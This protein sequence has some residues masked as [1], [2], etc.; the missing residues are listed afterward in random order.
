MLEIVDELY[1]Q[2]AADLHEHF[3]G[4]M[5]RGFNCFV[6]R[7]DLFYEMCE[8]EFGVLAEME[9]RLDIANYSQMLT[10][11]YG[12]MAELLYSAFIRTL[13]KRG[14]LRIYEPQMLFFQDTEPYVPLDPPENE[15]DAVALAFVLEAD[16][17]PSV[18]AVTL[19]SLLQ[20]VDTNRHYDI[21]LFSFD[22]KKWWQEYLSSLCGKH[23]NVTIRFANTRKIADSIWEYKE[24]YVGIRALLPYVLPAYNKIVSF[25][26]NMLFRCDPAQLFD[27]DVSGFPMLVTYDLNV[28][29]RSNDVFPEEHDRI[30]DYLGL[31]DEFSYFDSACMVMNLEEMRNRYNIEKVI[32]RESVS[33]GASD[34]DL[35]NI[36]YEGS[37]SYLDSKWNCFI[38]A[39][40]WDIN[41]LKNLPLRMWQ[42][43]AEVASSPCIIQYHPLDPWRQTGADVELEFWHHARELDI[44]E[45]LLGKIADFRA[46]PDQESEQESRLARMANAILPHGSL[47]RERVRKA[48]VK[49]DSLV[50]VMRHIINR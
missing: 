49:N 16:G 37:V 40:E 24:L 30:T 44:Y 3:S 27:M 41:R 2:Y 14:D 28:I 11:V 1:P 47:R 33:P 34:K 4:H 13:M 21:I 17:D 8:Y 9:K 32:A 31:K 38:P 22:M 7:K 45:L 29:S 12:Y 26:T 46:V 25:D 5:Y 39:Q 36:L 18:F 10:R 15:Q 19:C 48:I 43:Y 6:L 42:K 23:S 50:N 20:Q 35:L